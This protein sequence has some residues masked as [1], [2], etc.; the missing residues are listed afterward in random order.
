[1]DVAVMNIGEMRVRVSNRCVLVGMRVRLLT[2]P[3]EVVCV[4]VVLV[5][6]V[7]MVMV[8]DLVSVRMF[9]PLTD[10]QPDSKSH[11]RSRNPERHR[12]DLGPEDKG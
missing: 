4:L 9:M 11:E 7:P 1:V 2:V 8:Q 3:L 6:P 5:V 10:M 12:R